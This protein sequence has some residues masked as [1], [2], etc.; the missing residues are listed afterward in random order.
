MHADSRALK[1]RLISRELSSCYSHRTVSANRLHRLT[2][3]NLETRLQKLSGRV[4][5][6]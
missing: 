6:E 1:P 5:C 2:A 4:L 3:A